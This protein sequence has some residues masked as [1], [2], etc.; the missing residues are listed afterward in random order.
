MSTSKNAILK[1]V[2]F[3]AGF[4]LSF[5]AL[6]VMWIGTAWSYQFMMFVP[7]LLIALI[8]GRFGGASLHMLIGIAPIGVFFVQFR[9][10]N[11][12]HIF[13]ILLVCT[14]G[15]AIVLGHY[16]AMRWSR[17]RSESAR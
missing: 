11:N 6:G 16:L 14:W 1:T 10:N 5:I 17:L 15:I 12:S 4:I 7:F 9:D 8:L 3:A 2:G 13:P